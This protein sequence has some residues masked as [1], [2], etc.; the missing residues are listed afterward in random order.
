MTGRRLALMSLVVFAPIAHALDPF[1]STS[2]LAPPK[3]IVRGVELEQPFRVRI[4]VRDYGEET[5]EI[6]GQDLRD[7]NGNTVGQL[8]GLDG[9]TP[10][11]R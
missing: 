5:L 9:Q 6:A 10:R 3:L 11:A 1:P 8:L 2:T 7:E 4:L